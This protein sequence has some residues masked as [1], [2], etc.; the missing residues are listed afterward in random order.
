MKKISHEK[1]PREKIHLEEILSENN[2]TGIQQ[3]KIA[4]EENQVGKKA[5][6]KNFTWKK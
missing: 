5:N 3:E 2:R 4:S 6:T 1:I